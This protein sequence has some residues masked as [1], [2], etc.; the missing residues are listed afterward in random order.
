MIRNSCNDTQASTI[1]CHV[2]ELLHLKHLAHF[3]SNSEIYLCILY[4]TADFES[5]G[6]SPEESNCRNEGETENSTKKDDE[7]EVRESY[8]SVE[9]TMGSVRGEL[10]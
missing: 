10:L 7:A 1:L 8:N 9:W 6:K 3:H 4:T 5:K 2:Q